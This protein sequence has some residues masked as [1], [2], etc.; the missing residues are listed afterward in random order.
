MAKLEWTPQYFTIYSFFTIL[1]MTM[2]LEKPMKSKYHRLLQ[3]LFETAF[4]L[5]PQ[6]LCWNRAKYFR[7]SGKRNTILKVLC[8]HV[9]CVARGE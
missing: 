2:K 8:P 6:K 7:D 4:N 3:Y 1:S 5:I 9:G